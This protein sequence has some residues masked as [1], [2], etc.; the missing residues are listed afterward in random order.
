MFPLL[1]EEQRLPGDYRQ[2]E[3][4]KAGHDETSGVDGGNFVCIWP[5]LPNAAIYISPEN[6]VLVSLIP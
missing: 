4:I 5:S 6:S 3:G 2:E 1:N